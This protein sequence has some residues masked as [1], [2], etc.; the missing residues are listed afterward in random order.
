MAK[1]KLAKKKENKEMPTQ[2]ANLAACLRHFRDA[3]DQ[4][5]GKEIALLYFAP[6]RTTSPCPDWAAANVPGPVSPT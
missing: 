4:K 1:K 5:L 3:A 2:K 6:P